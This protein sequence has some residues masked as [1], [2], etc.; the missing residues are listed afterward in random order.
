MSGPYVLLQFGE[1][2]CNCRYEDLESRHA[3]TVQEVPH[4]PNIV[5]MLRREAAW[6]QQHPTI[7]GPDRSFL[8]FGP[9]QSQGHLAYGNSPLQPMANSIKQKRDSSNSR[10]FKSQNGSKEYKWKINPQRIECSDG[11]STIAVWELSQ[12]EDEFHARLT[13]RGG[14]LP[15]V[16]EILTTLTLNRVSLA[17][18]W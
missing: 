5:V 8:Y 16:T 10:Y 18:N 17:L 4:N 14:G 7:M 15:V 12:P 3:F 2:P 11:R 6:S 9:G 13:I 1:D